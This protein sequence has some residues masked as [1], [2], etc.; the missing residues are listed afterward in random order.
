MFLNEIDL[1]DQFFFF[2]VRADIDQL[3]D[4]LLHNIFSK[5]DLNPLHLHADY[6]EEIVENIGSIK[7][8]GHVKVS[9]GII[10]GLSEF[11]RL[12]KASM[13]SQ[14]GSTT[15]TLTLHSHNTTL[16]SHFSAHLGKHLPDSPRIPL[17]V[18]IGNI[19]IDSS[20]MVDEDGNLHLKKFIIR[21]I[22]DIKIRLKHAL[23]IEIIEKIFDK[24]VNALEKLF[25]HLVLDMVNQTVRPIFEKELQFIH[26]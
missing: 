9:K 11:H 25:N 14:D 22:E 2:L 12:G 4:E 5:P 13:K 18:S 1:I 3:V 7:I 6:D 16:D 15:L 8:L 19:I 10:Y 24:V 21:D 23:H 20:M 17:V 26:I